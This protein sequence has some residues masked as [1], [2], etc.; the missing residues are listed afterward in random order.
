MLAF[1]RFLRRKLFTRVSIISAVVGTAQTTKMSH[2]E[3]ISL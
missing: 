2:N 3:S 1:I